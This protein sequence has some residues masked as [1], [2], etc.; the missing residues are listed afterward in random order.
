V[1]NR[2]ISCQQARQIDLVDYLFELG[3]HPS[4]IRNNEYWYLSPLRDE[5]SA[6]FKINRALNRW[7]DHGIGRGGSLIDF[8]IQYYKCTVPELLATLGNNSKMDSIHCQP[9]Q[10]RKKPLK[11]ESKIKIIKL[12]LIK[13]ASLCKYLEGRRISLQIA[14]QYCSEVEFQLY[15]KKHT[16]LGFKNDAGGYELRNPYFKGSNSP[17][18]IT[19]IKTGARSLSVFEGFFDFLSFKTIKRGKNNSRLGLTNLKTDFLILNT[20][21]FFDSSR[22]IMESYNK[23]RLYLDRDRRGIE[24][25]EKASKWSVNY[26]DESRFYHLFKDLNEFLINQNSRRKNLRLI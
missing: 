10:V 19:T 7:F 14:N 24:S 9:P 3:Y 17:K 13:N 18:T 8:G 23:I 4:R 2:T 26:V 20:L 6:S 12:G 15:G 25:A 5:K 11:A 22:G 1:L 21:S 16:A